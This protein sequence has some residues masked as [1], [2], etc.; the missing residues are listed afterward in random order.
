M[1]VNTFV[2]IVGYA[3][4]MLIILYSAFVCSAPFKH[5][6]RLGINSILGCSLLS[7]ANIIFSR[8]GFVAGIN[9]V[10][11]VCVGV[12]GVPGA[13]AVIVLSLIL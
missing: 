3:L 13:V 11:A 6:V 9:P 5:I 12:L 8:Y 4:G 7:L 1:S 2:N 10:T